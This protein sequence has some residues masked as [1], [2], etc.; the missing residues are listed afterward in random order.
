MKDNTKK[1]L[2][3]DRELLVKEAITL[4]E[5][6]DWWESQMSQ[7]ETFFDELEQ[8]KHD[9]LSEEEVQGKQ[10]E[11]LSMTAR[12]NLEVK[13][14]D[15]FEKRLYDFDTRLNKFAHDD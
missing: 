1:E 2:L 9:H 4:Q 10:N 12:A 15:K 13:N 11:Y 7:F 5:S 3:K 8:G 6:I 14:I